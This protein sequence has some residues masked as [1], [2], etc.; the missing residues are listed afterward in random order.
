MGA[1]DYRDESEL[2]AERQEEAKA[3]R[4]DP[5]LVAFKPEEL[6]P[7]LRPRTSVGDST[8]D[9]IG[10]IAG[11]YSPVG[12]SEFNADPYNLF[13]KV[14][15]GLLGVTCTSRRAVSSTSAPTRSASPSIGRRCGSSTGR[16]PS[17]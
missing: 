14:D 9:E 8:R 5:D 10:T 16:N 17:A 7:R 4:W 1:D 13:D 11:V 2:N 3:R 6:E 15:Q 12:L